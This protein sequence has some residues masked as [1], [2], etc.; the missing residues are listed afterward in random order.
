MITALSLCIT[1]IA[2]LAGAGAGLCW[3]FQTA[4]DYEG[5]DL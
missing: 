2:A 1:V 5:D 3:A 4:L